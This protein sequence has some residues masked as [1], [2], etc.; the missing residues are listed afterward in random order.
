MKRS[1]CSTLI[2]GLFA[3][4]SQAGAHEAAATPHTVAP[5]AAAA[6]SASGIDVAAMDTGV[7]AQDDFFRYTQGKWL[8]DV[9]IPSDRS[10]WSAFSIAQERV[11]QQVSAIIGEAAS[12][13]NAKAGSEA[14]KMGDFYTSYVDEKRR[15]E[16]GLAPLKA[17]RARIDA[18][19]DKRELAGLMARFDRIDVGGPLGM[20]VGQDNKDSTRY[21]LGI[22]QSGLGMPNRDYYLQDEA[23]LKDIRGKYQ[24]HIGKM[25][26]LA[27][28]QDAEAKAE[29]IVALETEIA[30]AD[31]NT[32]A[33]AIG[34][35]PRIGR[36]FLN[37]G[38]GFGG[39]VV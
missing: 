34:V 38:L 29:R 16:L 26:A 2:A 28:H 22:S 7:R 12:Q 6:A 23:R 35:D 20:G 33:D 31:V 15:N 18:L 9:D 24:A 27:G 36:R 39:G 11:E 5:S 30:R 10:S 32:H 14:Q 21:I 25:L 19:K 4:A 1:L 13:K 8:K 37:A 3:V 17:E